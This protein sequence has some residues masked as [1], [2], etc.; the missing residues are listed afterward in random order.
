MFHDYRRNNV[1]SLIILFAAVLLIVAC[2]PKA[3]QPVS[4]LDT[5]QHHVY[6]GVKLLDQEKYSDAQ[7]EFELAL[8]LDNKYSKAHTGIGLVKTYMTP[9]DFKGAWDSLQKGAKY[10]HADDEI[11]FGKV[12][13]IRFYTQSKLEKKWL[14]LS[15]D[16]FD[17]AVKI[18]PKHSAAYYFMGLAYK[19]ACDFNAAGQMFAKVLELK[20][21]Y[22]YQADRE[23][24]FIQK[25][26]RAMPGSVTGKQIALVTRITRADAAALFMEE[27]KIDVLYK[28][29]TPK[30]FDTSF[31]DPEKA[32]QIAKQGKVTAKDIADHPLK[33]DIEGILEIGVRGLENY[34]DGNYHPGEIITRAA[35]AMM[36]EDILIKVTG[37]NA[38]ATKFIGSNSPF[39]DLRADLPYFNAVMVVTS[40]GIME[41]QDLTTGEFAPLKPVAG[42]DALLI[43]RKVK[44]GLKFN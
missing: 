38:L 30:A 10:A 8:E 17:A 25:V 40:R 14:N 13:N 36:L 43:I 12:S 9:A 42:V 16:E 26:Q 7:R 23:W 11:L 37:D 3:R 15:M 18:D 28:K 1:F 4:Q 2:G 35:Y 20:T 22:V 24:N 31:K 5:P 34:P 29:R 39:P 33:A 44:E 19:Q 41:A 27:L 6:T 32:A 21:D